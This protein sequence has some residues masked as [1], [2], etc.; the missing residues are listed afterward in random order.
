MIPRSL[1]RTPSPQ[2]G[3][4]WGEGARASQSEPPHPALSLLGRGRRGASSPFDV[5]PHSY[6][7]R[8]DGT[9]DME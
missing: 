6:D 5:P 8:S 4:G 2:R 1:M 3:E 9:V 7:D